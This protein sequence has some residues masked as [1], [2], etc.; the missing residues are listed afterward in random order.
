M[1]DTLR[2]GLLLAGDIRFLVYTTVFVSVFLVRVG[3]AQSVSAEKSR[4][5]WDGGVTI[6]WFLLVSEEVFYRYNPDASLSATFPPSAYAEACF[7]AV[8]SVALVFTWLISRTTPR[9]LLSSASTKLILFGLICMLSAAYAVRPG[10][11][12]AWAAKLA[13][14]IGLVSQ[15][16][17]LN[18][19]LVRM[20]QLL[21]VTLGGFLALS[22]V[23]I[24]R[25]VVEAGTS[26]IFEGGRINEL[27]S[28]I[29]LSERAGL[30][31]L[32][33]LTLFMR[34]HR[35]LVLAVGVV[36]GVI[37]VMGGGKTAIVAGIVSCTTF[38]LLQER[39][40][41]R[42]GTIAA[43]GFGVIAVFWLTPV[44]NYLQSYW[45]SGS[46]VTLSGRTNLWREAAPLIMQNPVFG[47][48]FL[49]SKYIHLLI[50]I[51]WPAPHL[52]N[53][54]LEVLYNTGVVGL[55]AFLALHAH[56]LKYLHRAIGSRDNSGVRDLAVGAL[57][58]YIYL[59]ING[60]LGETIGSRANAPFMMFIA[61]IPLSSTLLSWSDSARRKAVATCLRTERK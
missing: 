12:L 42:L 19:D 11:S 22:I 61:L 14:V 41:V 46:L 31:L 52:H 3:Y 23:R 5:A 25:A 24:G 26:G 34:R 4:A 2:D 39:V 8:A 7:W 48:G 58:I 35:L 13:L 47:H 9:K 1:S 29:V 55:G 59:T 15:L 17:Q 33:A 51:D 57:V 27:L 45:E 36:S 28:P 37:L 16:A 56:V 53:C 40:V 18:K 20:Q 30:A 49:S 10:F 44:A 32:L 54:F 60:L 43:I 21:E 50:D 6:W 38:A